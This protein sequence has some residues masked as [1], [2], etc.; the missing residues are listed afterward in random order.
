MA[1]QVQIKKNEIPENWSIEAADFVNKVIIHFKQKLL[2]RKPANRIGL[3]G[4]QEVKDH[5]WLKNYPWKDLYDK[6]IETS[7]IPKV[8]II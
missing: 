1:K 6:K 7:F 3:R 5:V 4:A 2:Q 8:S